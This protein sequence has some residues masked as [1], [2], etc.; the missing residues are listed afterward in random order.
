MICDEG[1]TVARG[2]V[3]A[4]VSLR[5][6]LI[7]TY[8]FL[9]FDFM[10]TKVFIHGFLTYSINIIENTKNKNNNINK[11]MKYFAIIFLGKLNTLYML[12][13]LPM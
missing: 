5:T 4:Y 8:D 10:I 6:S 13:A 12:I 2:N 1:A 7:I 3:C 9:I 11:K